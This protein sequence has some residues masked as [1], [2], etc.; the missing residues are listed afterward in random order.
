MNKALNEII[1]VMKQTYNIDI[2]MYDESFLLKS[3]GRRWGANQGNEAEKYV[4]CLEKSS[5]EAEAFYR[6]LNITYSEFFRNPLTFAL[7]EQYI[8]PSLIRQKPIGGEIRVWS[9]GCSAGQ[10]AYSIAMLLNECTDATGNALR[11]RIFATDISETALTLARTG[12]YDQEAI[13]HVTLKQ[14]H[15]YFSRE[16]DKYT[17]VSELKEHINFSTYDLM[18]KY[19]ANPPESIFGDFDIVFCSNLLFYYRPELRRLIIRKMENSMSVMGY[20]ITGEA[21]KAFMQ[22]EGK[23]EM[24]IPATAVFQTNKR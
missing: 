19:S 10:E 20:L 18:D 7:I 23:L 2:S 11:F 16:N 8:L 6:S 22:K 24:L 15:K 17:I 21:E 4:G 3:L 13:Q 12:R 1:Q 5:A 9:A 14:L